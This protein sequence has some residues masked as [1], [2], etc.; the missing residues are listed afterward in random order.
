M[1][2]Q[3]MTFPATYALACRF[4]CLLSMESPKF[5]KF[6]GIPLKWTH[7]S[8]VSARVRF[9]GIICIEKVDL[10]LCFKAKKR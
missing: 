7:Y 5:L 6:H 3:K 1:R 4:L 10:G 2:V 9:S 8:N